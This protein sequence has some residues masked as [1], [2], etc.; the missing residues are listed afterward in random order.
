LKLELYEIFIRYR[1]D[2]VGGR[3]SGAKKIFTVVPDNEH[4]ESS[5]GPFTLEIED[6]APHSKMKNS[7]RRFIDE[8]LSSLIEDQ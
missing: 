8:I 1:V 3:Q 6:V 4:V 5:S 7:I 2:I